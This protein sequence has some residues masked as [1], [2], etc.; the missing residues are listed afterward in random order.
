VIT[1]RAARRYARAVFDLARDDAGREAWQRD[2]AVMSDRLGTSEVLSLVGNPAV[3]T[4][5]KQ[6][7]VDQALARMD[8]LR[9]HLAYL[10]I[11]RGRLAELPAIAAEY[12]RLI[13]DHRGIAEA[14]VTTAV[15]LSES[16]ARD[17]QQKL[18]AM[19]G[20]QIV[21]REK[22]DPSIIG[23]LIVRIGD[24]LIDGSLATRLESLRSQLAG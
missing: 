1:T 13:R 21:L 17:V 10:L 3:T 8:R 9:L 6:A 23:G 5:A 4:A 11:E 22:V 18:A 16:D 2:L 24:R 15:P 7:L 20:K 19:T 12:N 14:E